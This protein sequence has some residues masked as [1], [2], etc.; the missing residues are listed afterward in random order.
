TLF[1]IQALAFHQLGFLIGRRFDFHANLRGDEIDRIIWSGTAALVGYPNDIRSL[2]PFACLDGTLRGASTASH[3]LPEQTTDFGLV[4]GVSAARRWTHNDISPTVSLNAVGKLG[5]QLIFA[6]LG[7]V[8][9]FSIHLPHGA[10]KGIFFNVVKFK[11]V[12]RSQ[13]EMR[14]KVM[15]IVTR[16]RWLRAFYLPIILGASLHFQEPL[17]AAT[18][19][20][21]G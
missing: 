7:P 11:F 13:Q 12:C 5:Q 20:S 18:P 1:K 8:H 19:G 3:Q 2:D 6:N 10:R 14:T 17:V 9:S 21:R 15:R 4:F 16:S